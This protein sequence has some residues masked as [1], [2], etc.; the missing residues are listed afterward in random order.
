MVAL[1]SSPFVA[2]FQSFE[3]HLVDATVDNPHHVSLRYP[4]TYILWQQYRLVHFIV[5][6]LLWCLF[7][8][9]I[10]SHF[11]RF[12][13]YLYEADPKDR[14]ASFLP[15]EV[16]FRI[17]GRRVRYCRV[18]TKLTTG[19]S[20]YIGAEVKALTVTVLLPVISRAISLPTG[21]LW[22]GGLPSVV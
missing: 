8:A 22:V 17:S 16:Y 9:L 19:L 6:E 21:L 15:Q 1:R 11:P 4:L 3:I 18:Y 20:E 13:H 10:E 5:L 14:S 7:H 12:V 2:V